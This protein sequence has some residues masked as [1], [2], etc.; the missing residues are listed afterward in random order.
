MALYVCWLV[1]D[2]QLDKRVIQVHVSIEYCNF[3]AYVRQNVRK[4]IIYANTVTIYSKIGDTHFISI[5]LLSP[6][7]SHSEESDATRNIS[8]ATLSGVRAL[9]MEYVPE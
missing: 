8:S 4:L 1:T 3:H 9:Y 6:Q 5:R 2:R 7:V